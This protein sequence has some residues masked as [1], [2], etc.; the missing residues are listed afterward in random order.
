MR[1][2]DKHRFKPPYELLQVRK[3][4]LQ[5]RIP[6]PFILYYFAVEPLTH[7]D[8]SGTSLIRLDIRSRDSVSYLMASPNLK[9]LR[10]S[11]VGDDLAAVFGKSICIETLVFACASEEA[12]RV[13]VSHRPSAPSSLRVLDVQLEEYDKNDLTPP[14]VVSSGVIKSH[15][16]AAGTSNSNLKQLTV[17][18]HEE[19]FTP[20][21]PEGFDED[22]DIVSMEFLEKA[23]KVVGLQSVCEHMGIVLL[24]EY[25]RPLTWEAEITG[26]GW[27]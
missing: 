26:V 15:L 27:E 10:T 24:L 3:L 23:T 21:A 4:S 22:L 9:Y 6:H 25:C 8:L 17:R 18:P 13:F 20:R 11:I 14:Y 16:L 19:P 7:L 12:L 2:E 1:P 5:H